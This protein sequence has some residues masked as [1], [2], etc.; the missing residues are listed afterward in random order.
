M[1]AEKSYCEA[2]RWAMTHQQLGQADA[3]LPKIE[4]ILNLKTK[5]QGI[6][7]LHQNAV[8]KVLGNFCDWGIY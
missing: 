1:R 4:N 6:K 8:I 5:M 7:K 2:C 3:L